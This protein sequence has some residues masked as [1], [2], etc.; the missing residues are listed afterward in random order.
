MDKRKDKRFT[1]KLYVKLN[2]VTKTFWGVLDEISENGLFIRS[3]QGFTLDAVIDIEIFM[4]DNIIILLKGVVRR[5]T[6]LPEQHRKFGLGIE[7][8]K[9]DATHKDF[10]TFLDGQTK[11]TYATTKEAV[12]KKLVY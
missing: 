9:K 4:P 11:Q 5:I 3:N 6:E 2:S 12:F 8:I 1:T 10:L 7:L